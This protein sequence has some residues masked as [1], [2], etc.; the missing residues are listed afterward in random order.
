MNTHNTLAT[1]SLAPAAPH[2]LQKIEDRFTSDMERVNR[3]RDESNGKAKAGQLRD[4]LDELYGSLLTN[5][6]S[7]K[8]LRLG[9][10]E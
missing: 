2:V 7:V 3:L 6:L 8:R 9:I 4:E 1:G 10:T 5:Y